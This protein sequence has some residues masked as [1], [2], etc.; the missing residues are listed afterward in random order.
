MKERKY[1]IDELK[2]IRDK[3]IEQANY[4]MATASFVTALIVLAEKN[5]DNIILK[6][7]IKEES[8]RE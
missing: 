2:R 1:T 4:Y 6:D 8:P 3:Q 5:K 7:I